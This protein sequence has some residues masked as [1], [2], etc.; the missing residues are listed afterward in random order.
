MICELFSTSTAL[1]VLCF[2]ARTTSSLSVNS[3]TSR[4][5]PQSHSRK[6]KKRKERRRYVRTRILFPAGADL[7]S[8]SSTS[9]GVLYSATWEHERARARM[10]CTSPHP[11]VRTCALLWRRDPAAPHRRAWA[12]AGAGRSPLTPLPFTTCPRRPGTP[13]SLSVLTASPAR[14]CSCHRTQTPELRGSRA[15]GAGGGTHT[16]MEAAVS[17]DTPRSPHAPVWGQ[18]C[19]GRPWICDA[20]SWCF[21]V[22]LFFFSPTSHLFLCKDL[23]V[24]L[25][26]TT[27]SQLSMRCSGARNL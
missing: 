22:H 23:L 6:V 17:S 4:T 14:R 26:T 10:P 9:S 13:P 3:P 16:G 21:P 18:P 27:D 5:H 15:T 11:Q 1:E 24:E 7:I 2:S 8:S 20:H 12:T 19:S 25:V